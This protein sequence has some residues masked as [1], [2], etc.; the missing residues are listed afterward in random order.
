MDESTLQEF[1]EVDAQNI[2]MWKAP[3]IE[4]IA[5]PP[6][7]HPEDQTSLEGF[8]AK[9]P[10]RWKPGSKKPEKAVVP[11]H[12]ARSPRTPTGI[13]RKKND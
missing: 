11:D 5:D 7:G 2:E 10:G 9:K 6:P 4:E 1:L 13:S 12:T 8:F 3:V